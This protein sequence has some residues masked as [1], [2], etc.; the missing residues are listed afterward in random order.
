LIA[1]FLNIGNFL[2]KRSYD[3]LEGRR[4]PEFYTFP[5]G[6]SKNTTMIQVH[7]KKF[8]SETLQLRSTRTIKALNS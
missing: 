2:A 8:G 7:G 5:V 6:L 1:V 4:E 3:C